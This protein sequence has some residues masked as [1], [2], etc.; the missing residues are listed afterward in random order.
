[1][2]TSSVGE[3]DLAAEIEQ[4]DDYMERIHEALAMIDKALQ[5]S[6]PAI[7]RRPSDGPPLASTTSVLPN[8][9]L[10]PSHKVKLPKIQYGSDAR[11]NANAF[12]TQNKR[13]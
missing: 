11:Y 5:K 9:T 3:D 12:R 2:S 4:A 1:M 13:V 10:P 7:C 6:N 8:A